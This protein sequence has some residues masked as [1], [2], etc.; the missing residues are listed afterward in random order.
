MKNIINLLFCSIFLLLIGCEENVQEQAETESSTDKE[1]TEMKENTDNHVEKQKQ[2]DETEVETNLTPP[3]EQETKVLY[4]LNETNWALEP[5][6][7]GT[8]ENVVLLTID[9]VP[10][11]H[12]L[13]MATLL[14]ELDA[15]A[16]F[17]ANGHFLHQEE[18]KEM[19]RQIHELGFS[20]GNH[21]MTHPNLSQ[22]SE[23]EQ[24]E[25]ILELNNLIEEIIGEK[26]TFFRAPHGVNTEYVRELVKQEGMLLMNWTYGYDYFEPYQ[27]AEK[28]KE[29]MITGEGP[30]VDVNYSL[31]RPGA[32]L[33]MHDREWTLDALEDI[34]IGL[35]EKGYSFVDPATIEIPSL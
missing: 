29:A 26:P 3:A 9:D 35:R 27:D 31:L 11:N 14:K 5:I 25:E 24:R 8:D 23:A 21:T 28:L 10:D 17:F 4:R 32:N 33:L 30:E 19:L 34:V 7:E 1:I 12:A 13:E 20:I 15:P 18:N 16:I 6:E 22:I 2:P